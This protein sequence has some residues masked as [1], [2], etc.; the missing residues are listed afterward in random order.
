MSAK[1]DNKVNVTDKQLILDIQAFIRERVGQRVLADIMYPYSEVIVT[2]VF[3]FESPNAFFVHVKGKGS[4][5]CRKKD[6]DHHHH[7]VYFEIGPNYETK[8]KGAKWVFQKCF[9]RTASCKK[10]RNKEAA[11]PSSL[12]ARLF[13]EKVAEVAKPPQIFDVVKMLSTIDPSI[14]PQEF[15]QFRSRK[16]EREAEMGLD[17]PEK[18]LKAL[19]NNEELKRS[20]FT[21]N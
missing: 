18:R 20:G 16:R 10:F 1:N 3:R 14:D 4:D 6:D 13:N 11:F 19:L 2:E 9:C 5:D 15:E 21:L 17:D 8:Q 7:K 12:R